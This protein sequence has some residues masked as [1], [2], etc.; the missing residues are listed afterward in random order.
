MPLPGMSRHNVVYQFRPYEL[1]KLKKKSI[2]ESAASLPDPR[3]G[4]R[5]ACNESDIFCFGGYSPGSEDTADAGNLFQELWKYNI[6]SKRWTL[7][8]AP[9]AD[10]MPKEVASC[11]ATIHGN[12]LVIHGGTGFPFGESSSNKCYVFQT[13]AVE[14]SIVELEATGEHPKAQYGQAVTIADNFLYSIGGTTG[15][16]YSCD[17]H[18]LDLVHKDW[19]CMYTSKGNIQD[20][21]SGRYRHGVVHCDGLLY[22]L[23]GGTSNSVFDLEQIPVFNLVSCSWTHVQTKPDEHAGRPY[24]YP[25]PRRCHSCIQYETENGTEAIIAGGCGENLYFTDIWKL[26]I[27]TLKWTLMKAA[28]LPR[29][30]FFHDACITNNSCMYIFGGIQVNGRSWSRTNDLMKMWVRIPKL[31]EICWDAISYY[32]P[33]LCKLTKLELLRLGIPKEFAVRINSI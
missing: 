18:R 23:G 13:S 25:A 29:P 21:P 32:A 27:K 26:N 5:I 31:S 9:G 19:K 6:F 15:F 17:V 11:T 10:D 28:R 3:S 12:I 1:K 4:H 20:D 16:D 33:N 14:P 7:V 22:V 24:G 2:E 8:I 30:L